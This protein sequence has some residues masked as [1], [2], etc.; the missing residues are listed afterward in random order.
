MLDVRRKG[1]PRPC[2]RT[3]NLSAKG[4]GVDWNVDARPGDEI[5][6]ELSFPG[7]LRRIEF[8]ARVEWVTGDRLCGLRA[9][10]LE[11]P[12]DALLSAATRLRSLDVLMV[13]PDGT[14]PRSNSST[15]RI[16]RLRQVSSAECLRRGEEYDVIALPPHAR[17]QRGASVLAELLVGA[18][19]RYAGTV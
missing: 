16:R 3:R 15:V 2:G 13:D 7:I 12:L 4:L 19:A 18:G 10:S 8:N 6:I 17:D 11:D 9:R 5:A 14:L 1:D